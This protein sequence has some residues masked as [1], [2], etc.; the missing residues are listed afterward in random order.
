MKADRGALF[1]GSGSFNYLEAALISALALRKHEPDLP[2][3]VFSDLPGLDYINLEDTS[4]AIC[5]VLPE[6]EPGS[7]TFSSRWV[8]TRLAKLSPY[9]NSLYV[10]AD[11][12]AMQPLGDLWQVLDRAPIGLVRDRLPLVSLCDHVAQEEKTLTLDAVGGDATHFN[13]GLILWRSEQATDSLFD[14]WH[15]Q[16]RRFSR[17]DQ[18]ALVRAIFSSEV[19]VEILPNSYNLSPRDARGRQV[20]FLH[21]W[22]GTVERGIF[23]RFA[24]A[25]LPDVAADAHRRLELLKQLLMGTP[26][27]QPG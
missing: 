12:L 20:H 22:G 11:M 14:H 5:L 26:G 18:L 19:Q 10:D 24:A 16:W 25:R 9:C 21:R 23:R 27:C 6:V 3:T 13:S 17:Q 7:N 15:Q 1:C 4:I 2:I 8:K